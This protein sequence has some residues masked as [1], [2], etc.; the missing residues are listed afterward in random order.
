MQPG[1]APHAGVAEEIA[2]TMIAKNHEAE[3]VPAK[4][5][6][7]ISDYQAIVLGTSIHASRTVGSFNQFLT[8][9]HT[10]METK[11]VFIFVVCANMME[12][13]EEN[14]AETM[15]WLNRTLV[16][17]PNIKPVSIG[18][19]G[20]AIITDGEDYKGLN[21]LVRKVINSMKDNIQKQF[22][23]ID[24]RDWQKIREWAESILDQI[25]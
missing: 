1:Q 10:E 9:F 14:R 11:P 23:K 20:G 21:F 2:K 16:K 18:L 5:V 24:F 12:D 3:V 7:S 22:G 13:N 8:Q 6:K 17:Y 19:F 4:A 25:K 15:E